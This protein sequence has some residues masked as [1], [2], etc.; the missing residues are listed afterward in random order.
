MDTYH[1]N[2][3][4]ITDDVPPLNE[5]NF[6][7][8]HVS[9]SVDTLFGVCPH[10]SLVLVTT[11]ADPPFQKSIPNFVHNFAYVDAGRSGDDNL[12]NEWRVCRECSLIY[13]RA[14]CPFWL[15]EDL[16]TVDPGINGQ[17]RD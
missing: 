13:C 1:S 12:Y 2:R 4:I 10:C 15:N 6:F 17:W 11:R 3:Y 16:S 5:D 14:R 8:L 9:L 7:Y